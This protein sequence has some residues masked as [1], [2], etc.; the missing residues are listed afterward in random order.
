VN[1]RFGRGLW[2]Q[3]L[4]GSDT[5]KRHDRRTILDAIAGTG[6]K[7]KEFEKQVAEIATQPAACEETPSDTGM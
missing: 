2:G 5:R 7:E 6:S 4:I 3:T 1:R